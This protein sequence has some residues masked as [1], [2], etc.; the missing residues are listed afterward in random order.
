MPVRVLA[1][2]VLAVNM[3][4]ITEY[5]RNI[6]KTGELLQNVVLKTVDV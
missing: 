6:A 2:L 3:N 1:F 5:L 4:G